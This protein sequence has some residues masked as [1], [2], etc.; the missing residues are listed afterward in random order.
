MLMEHLF[1][2]YSPIIWYILN[3]VPL[4][5]KLIGNLFLHPD[6]CVCSTYVYPG[7]PISSSFAYVWGDG[8]RNVLLNVCWGFFLY[9]NIQRIYSIMMNW[10]SWEKSPKN[11]NVKEKKNIIHHWRDAG[12]A[13]Y[14]DEGQF[15]NRITRDPKSFNRIQLKIQFS[16]DLLLL[17][18]T[19]GFSLNW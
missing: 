11:I 19:R 10:Y 17:L 14:L 5:V 18:S 12:I 16:R 8:W 2:H 1:Y 3:V 9:F 6:N 7:S 15:V 4:F 13:Q